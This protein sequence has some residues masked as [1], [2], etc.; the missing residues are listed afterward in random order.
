[1]YIT[2]SHV[3]ETLTGKW[4]GDVMKE[5]I[6]KPLGMNSTYLSLRE[7][8][9]DPAHLAPSYMWRDEEEKFEEL[10][11]VSASTFSGAG[12]I[13]SNVLDFTKWIQC[14]INE[15]EP[16]SKATHRDIRTPRM[17]ENVTPSD[18]LSLYGLAWSRSTIHGEVVYQHDGSTLA[19]G[20]EVYWLPNIKYGVIAL[21]NEAM[22]SNAAERVLVQ[23]LIEERLKVPVEDRVDVNKRCVHDAKYA[24]NSMAN[25][26]FTRMKDIF[27]QQRRNLENADEI[28][29][30]ERPKQPQPSSLRVSE[31][32][33]T[34]HDAG[35]GTVTLFEEPHPDKP[36]ESLLAANRTELLWAQ[37]WQMHHVSGNFWTS[38]NKLLISNINID[39]EIHAA[40]FKIGVDGKVHGFEVAVSDRNG[41]HEER[42]LFEKIG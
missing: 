26:T 34:Y 9:D 33:G 27:A 18:D 2:L 38:I 36:D 6:W 16:F 5:V 32:A 30:P 11:F 22:T 35:Y 20:A 24:P 13:I 15:S 42:V 14:L 8:Q 4:L 10:P 31:L 19:Y 21:A 39:L 3:I 37:K 7:A 25:R 40:E 28:L 12:G 41:P 1:M 23:A 29:Y 17:M